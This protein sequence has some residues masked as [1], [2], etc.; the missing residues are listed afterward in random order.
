M[1]K[2]DKLY[3]KIIMEMKG[4]LPSNIEII[5]NVIQDEFIP[6]GFKFKPD[7]KDYLSKMEE[8]ILDTIKYSN[9][10]DE[11]DTIG[12]ID[13]GDLTDLVKEAFDNFDLVIEISDPEDED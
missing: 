10:F 12:S 11:N 6:E 9:K 4:N 5:E 13:Y 1:N 3:K 8:Y 7:W 2:F